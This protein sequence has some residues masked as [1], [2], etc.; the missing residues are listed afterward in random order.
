MNFYNKTPFVNRYTI[1]NFFSKDIDN[2]LGKSASIIYSKSGIGKSRLCE[3]ILK[4]VKNSLAKVKVSINNSK[5]D[6]SQDGFYIKQIAKEINKNSSSINSISMEEFLQ[7]DAEKDTNELMYKI[8]NDYMEKSSVLKNVKDVISKFFSIGNFNS[9]KIFDSNLAESIKLSYKYIEYCCK[10]NYFIINIENIQNIDITSLELLVKLTSKTEKLYLLLEYTILS[11][12]NS[13]I[14]DELQNSLSQVTNLKIEAKELEQLNENELIKLLESNNDLLKQYIKTSYAKW[15]GNLRPFVNLHYNLPSSQE[16][17][18]NFI[19]N[20]NN[21]INNIV[22][23][24]I[25]GLNSKEIFLLIFIAIHGDSVELNL[26]NQIHNINITTDISNI[27]DFELELNKLVEKRFLAEYNKSYMINDDTILDI[28]LNFRNFSSKKILATQ[29]WLAI[30]TQIY[31]NEN[32]YFIS[33]SALIFNILNFS[34]QLQEEQNILK[35]LNELMFLFRNSTPIWV[36]D[37]IQKIL[38]SIKNSTNEYINNLIIIRLSEITQNL[39]L[40]DTSYSLVSSIKSQDDNLLL[41]KAILLENNS[42]PNEALDIIDAIFEKENLNTRLY[43]V[44]KINQISS[45]RSINDYKKAEKLFKK[46][47]D[48]D[49]YKN[50][51]EFGFVLRLAGTIFDSRKALPFVIQSIEHFHS[52]N[53]QIQELHSRIELSVMYIYNKDFELAREQLDIASKISQENFIEN[54]IIANNL[55]IVNLYQNKDI[56]NTYIMLKKCLSVVQTP[57]DKLALHINLLI[58]ANCL[59][60]DEELILNLC[61][62]IDELCLLDNISDKEIKRISYLNLMF[63]SKK[64]GNEEKFNI[65]KN[66]FQ[67]IIVPGNKYELDRKF[68]MLINDELN[69]SIQENCVDYFITCELSHW[70]IEFDNILKN[71]E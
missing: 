33:K 17:I 19:S 39:S 55:A 4:D 32:H 18:K 58:S 13:L 54:Y 26:I 68:R 34:V 70:S 69:L 65:Y 56:S 1:L 40:Y 16:E 12:K 71:F 50:Y 47:L 21:T 8:A 3:E 23:N 67:N 9:N 38:D 2:N 57:F 10:N 53:A 64:L 52:Y 35:Y 29:L 14:L 45:L 7:M 51:L 24:D 22:I 37:W 6:Y 66:R 31:N 30:Y 46:L 43:L 61:T 44:C 60:L 42:K 36:K 5:V 63:S 25:L 28:L 59:N 48:N 49:E 11:N 20:S 62:T 27:F 41:I 15:D